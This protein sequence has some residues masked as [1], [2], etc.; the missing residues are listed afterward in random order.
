MDSACLPFVSKAEKLPE[1][2]EVFLGRIR[3]EIA[4]AIKPV[5]LWG[6]LV[7]QIQ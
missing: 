4:N 7:K 2:P 5:P 1:S 6:D 3:F